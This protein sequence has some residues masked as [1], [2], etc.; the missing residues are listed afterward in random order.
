LTSHL[1]KLL[2]A[3]VEIRQNPDDV[4]RAA[5]RGIA[6]FKA[7]HSRPPDPVETNVLAQLLSCVLD[8]LYSS[9]QLNRA[10]ARPSA[11]NHAIRNTCVPPR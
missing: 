10:L 5:P 3:T 6:P 11:D 4:E 7:G 8:E 2:D 1:D 9:Y